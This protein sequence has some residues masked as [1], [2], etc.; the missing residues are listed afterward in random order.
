MFLLILTVRN[1]DSIR[2]YSFRGNIPA[3]TFLCSCRFH[4]WVEGL[5]IQGSGAEKDC[6][7]HGGVVRKVSRAVS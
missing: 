3:R 5:T 4:A 1:R 2:G 7:I 6:G